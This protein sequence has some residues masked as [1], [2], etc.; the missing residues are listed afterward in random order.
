MEEQ[1]TSAVEQMTTATAPRRN[2][3]IKLVKVL[4][5]NHSRYHLSDY[6]GWR[7]L[8][9]SYNPMRLAPLYLFFGG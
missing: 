7:A 9:F 8:P 3:R 2:I 1:K 6:R 4:P 5:F